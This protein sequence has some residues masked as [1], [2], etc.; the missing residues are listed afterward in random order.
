MNSNIKKTTL[1]TSIVLAF[2]A[3][4]AQAALVT[5]VLGP[6][7]WSTDSA[8]F[9]ML[10]SY[11]NGGTLPNG[12]NDVNMVWDGNGYSA[13]SDYTGPGSAANVTASSTSL[14]FGHAWTAHDIQV[15]TPGSYSF[16]VTLGGG[17]PE[18][19]TLN[20]TVGAGQLGMHMLF[21]WL[22][23]Y[24]IDVFVVLAQNSVFGSGLL[25]STQ[26]NTKGELTCHA[27]YTGT[28][29]KNCLYDGPI[30]GSAGAPVKNQIWMLASV[31]GNGDGIMGIPMA[32]GGPFAGFNANFNATL[33]PQPVP[34]PAAVWLFG[35]GLL[36]LVGA[37]R[38]KNS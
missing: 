28:I 25:Y 16:D 31:D 20:V 5:N 1:A 18:T 8:N 4:N 13:S 33:S 22:Y 36:S 12:A 34:V 9:T 11:N 35:S 2:G 38:R 29:T 30:Y 24:N 19:G 3:T 10:A 26:Q 17:V 14:F 6:Y 32:S 37:R 27:S 15:F 21:D 23:N 7:T